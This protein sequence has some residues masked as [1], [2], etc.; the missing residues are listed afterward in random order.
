[1]DI[2]Y[3]PPRPNHF[4]DRLNPIEEF[5]DDFDLKCRLR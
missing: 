4:R 5:A 2:L 1:M 3:Q